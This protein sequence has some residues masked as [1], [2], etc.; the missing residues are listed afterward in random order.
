MRSA[1]RVCVALALLI[2]VMAAVALA[3]EHRLAWV[4]RFLLWQLARRGIT[5]A[6]LEV[7]RAG[8]HE[9]ALR[10]LRIGDD[11]LALDALELEF[12]PA[13]L[14]ARRL[15]AARVGE[16]RVRGRI[17]SAGL[18]L[19]ALD[20]LRSDSSGGGAG[21]PGLPLLPV[22][23][24]EIERAVLH[25]D[26]PHGLF[27]AALSL[28]LDEA[29]RGRFSGYTGALATFSTP[30][31]VAAA[32]FALVG[33]VDFAPDR[34]QVLLEPA[35]FS[36][37]L[38]TR[39]GPQPM[40]GKTPRLSLQG[41]SSLPALEIAGADGE[42]AL[43]GPG[44]AAQG[45]GFE[46]R[47]ASQT[48]LPG[49]SLAVQ[50]LRDRREPARFAPLRL[51]AKLVPGE[52]EL[53]VEGELRSEL[54]GLTARFDGA[55]D[56]AAGSG[57]AGVRLEP[58]RFAERGLQPGDLLPG[59]TA[60][61]HSVAGEVD[62]R[63]ELGWGAGAAKSSADLGLRDL[64]FEIGGA[65]FERVNTAL[66]VEGPWP[67]RTPRGQL[68]SIARVDLGLELTDGLV[69]F[70]LGRDGAIEVEQAEWSFAG[71]KLRSAG[72]FDPF[73]AQQQIAMTVAG[74][75]L[76]AL[77]ALVNLDGLGGSGRLEGRLPLS[78]GPDSLRIEG[79]ELRA[80]DEGGVIRYRPS[81]RAG[82]ALG[83]AGA[84]LDDFLLALREFHYERLVL[85]VNGD[86]HREVAVGVSLAGANPEHR[87][88]QPYSFNL[89]LEGR[90]G[91]LV[92]KESA[93]Y[94]IPTEIQKR[95][96]SISRDDRQ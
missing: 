59:L 8:L 56:L 79:A 75:D 76:A 23:R 19:G 74:V 5:D 77:L 68:V 50:R 61:V 57:R 29:G 43:L 46:L 18:R 13:G 44:V 17:D 82:E 69:R 3:A 28:E 66:R 7:T 73:A 89:N 83:S 33:E 41:G 31:G 95:L 51:E 86:P 55:H 6:S 2:G 37:T 24:L 20:A 94:R 54:R 70:E 81:G 65:R 11:E 42:V 58:L 72:R 14:V 38:A 67:P 52:H 90:L 62:A 45:L 48:H 4:E 96:E 92:R 93:A 27:E 64:S 34:F 36:L 60:F 22:G 85:R 9:L 63:G 80:S 25:L 84:A 49:G 53:A 40:T 16:L 30:V 10:E 78:L 26:T 87:D 1:A 71:G 88:G 15:D 35:A 39:S 47:I 21:A 12:S 32:P 91:D